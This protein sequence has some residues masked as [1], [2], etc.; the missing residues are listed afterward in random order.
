MTVS[1]E[2]VVRNHGNDG[3]LAAGEAMRPVCLQLLAKRGGEVGPNSPRQAEGAGNEGNLRDD[4]LHASVVRRHRKDMATGEARTPD[5][6][7]IR[8]DVGP[9]NSVGD[10]VLVVAILQDG[11]E[12]LA[13]GPVARPE[14][15]MVV[16]HDVEASCGEDLS[17]FAESHLFD[18]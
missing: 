7:P 3:G 12:L 1:A 11:V 6:Y 4:C 9:S 2:R 14:V 5:A 17:V 15:L 18:A 13:W 16:D 10:R 8:V